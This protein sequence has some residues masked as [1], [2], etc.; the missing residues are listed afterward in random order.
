MAAASA[1]STPAR[2]SAVS[3]VSPRFSTI[4]MGAGLWSGAAG[5]GAWPMSGRARGGS[6][7]R[8]RTATP[9]TPRASRT[10]TATR[11]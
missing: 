5:S 4:S 1:R 8:V 7:A 10:V 9:I 11:Q 3:R 2:R 6:G